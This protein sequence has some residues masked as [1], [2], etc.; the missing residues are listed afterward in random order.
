VRSVRSLRAARTTDGSDRSVKALRAPVGTAGRRTHPS[1]ADTAFA[2]VAALVGRDRRLSP[3]VLAGGGNVP[4]FA[5]GFVVAGV[6]VLP[7]E[8]STV[9]KSGDLFATGMIRGRVRVGSRSGPSSHTDHRRP[10]RAQPAPQ[11]SSASVSTTP[12]GRTRCSPVSVCCSRTTRS[13]SAGV[14]RVGPG[15]VVR[16]TMSQNCQWRRLRARGSGSSRTVPP[17]APVAVA[18]ASRGRDSGHR[19]GR[20]WTAFRELPYPAGRHGRRWARDGTG[21]GRRRRG[22]RYI[23]VGDVLMVCFTMCRLHPRGQAPGHSP[24]PRVNR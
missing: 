15:I 14:A 9:R 3:A 1:R 8:L 24:R 21:R 2:V 4:H 18:L 17:G 5:A 13:V 12:G 22:G 11:P 10:R 16:S 20:A 19:S 7:R 6:V 23:S